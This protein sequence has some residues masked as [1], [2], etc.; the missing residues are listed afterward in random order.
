MRNSFTSATLAL[1]AVLACSHF[2]LAQDVYRNTE[3]DKLNL[4]TGGP[5]PKQDLS[6]SWAGPVAIDRQAEVTPLTPW[7]RN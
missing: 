7:A 4:G 5:A 3:Y 1:T 2:T 6:G